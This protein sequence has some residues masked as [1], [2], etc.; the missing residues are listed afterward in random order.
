MI[1]YKGFH[2][3]LSCMGKKFKE[4][5]WSEEK[6][7]NCVRNGFHC[8][9][10]PLDCLHYYPNWDESVYYIVLAE[11]DIDEDGSDTK[12][13][14]TRIKPIHK[15]TRREFVCEAMMYMQ[16]NP[17]MKWNNLVQEECGEHKNN[18]NMVIV[19]GEDPKAKGHL[20]DVIGLAIEEEGRVTEIAVFEIDGDCFL[21]DTFYNI[22][23]E[24][25]VA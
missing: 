16:K 9:S 2:K 1:A 10:D 22:S 14:C 20:G 7:A 17:N 5:Q 12:I 8:A 4:N 24:E 3:D 25:V 6:E 13:A 11:G 19:R 15:L 21:P 23:G 18:N